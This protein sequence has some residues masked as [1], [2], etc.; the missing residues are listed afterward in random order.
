MYANLLIKEPIEKVIEDWDYFNEAVVSHFATFK[1]KG[2][3]IYGLRRPDRWGLKPGPAPIR[4]AEAPPP[5][6]RGTGTWVIGPSGLE[7]KKSG[8]LILSVTPGGHP[9]HV[10]H[11]FGYW[12]VNDMDEL[13]L[14]IPGKGDEPGFGLLI[15]G[16]PGPG[17]CDRWA[18]YCEECLTLLFERKWETGLKGFSGFWKAERSAVDDYNA[19][20]RNQV[21]PECGHVNPKGYVASPLKD[22]PEEREA[23]AQW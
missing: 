20:P 16:I 18:W 12:H 21:C 13:S 22:T 8:D 3:N 1:E 15:M 19:E 14:R 2:Q 23:R 7:L 6:P 9:H 4:G 17:E 10:I 5:P 11:S